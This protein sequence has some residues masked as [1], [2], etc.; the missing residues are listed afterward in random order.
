[1]TTHCWDEKASGRWLLE[2]YD[3]NIRAGSGKYYRPYFGPT[4]KP[5]KPRK[6]LM[7]VAG[8]MAM[9]KRVVFQL[10]LVFSGSFIWLTEQTFVLVS[11]NFEG[12][13]I[14]DFW[15]QVEFDQKLMVRF[16]SFL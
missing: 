11:L 7:V 16:M 14:P 4:K 15:K 9:L 6:W 5:P 12:Q 10:K 13:K 2:I 3:R 1:M 8:E